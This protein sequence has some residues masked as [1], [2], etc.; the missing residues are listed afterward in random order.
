MPPKPGR[1]TA[2]AIANT[3]PSIFCLFE[4][5]FSRDN[6]FGRNKEFQLA[7]PESAPLF[8]HEQT[9]SLAKLAQFLQVR[10]W[11]FDWLG[12]K[13]PGIRPEL[14]AANCKILFLVRDVR[15]WAVKNRIIRSI[16]GEHGRSNIVPFLVAYADYLLRSYLAMECSRIRLDDVLGGDFSMFPSAVADFFQVPSDNIKEWWRK[17]DNWI[18]MPPKNYSAWVAG[19]KSAFMPP[20]YSDTAA[21]LRPHD[22]WINYLPIFDKYFHGGRFS[23]A[24]IAK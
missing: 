6:S 23:D 20:V 8:G 24:E 12:T 14:F 2:V 13:I 7:F 10:G 11:E 3:H 15:H 5:D 19:H 4:V 17:A 1:L 16:Y 9:E 18:G 22:F 21:T